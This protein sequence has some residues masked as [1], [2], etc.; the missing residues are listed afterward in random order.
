MEDV[1]RQFVESKLG[2]KNFQLKP[3]NIGL[4]GGLVFKAV[5]TEDNSV[6]FFVKMFKENTEILAKDVV[7]LDV[8]RQLPLRTSSSPHPMGVGKA[9][10]DGSSYGFFAQTV[11]KGVP[12]SSMMSDVGSKEEHSEERKAAMDKLEVAIR[13]VGR[14]LAELWSVRVDQAAK[15]GPKVQA[16]YLDEL[17]WTTHDIGEIAQ[18]IS[19]QDMAIL[20]ELDLEAVKKAAVLL[21]ERFSSRPELFGVAGYEHTDTN[22][23]NLFFD[24]NKDHLTLIDTEGVLKS[25]GKDGNPIGFPI[26][27]KIGFG[28]NSIPN[29]GFRNGLT[30]NEVRLLTAAFHQAYNDAISPFETR[31]GPLC[32]SDAVN[33]MML[34]KHSGAT[35]SIF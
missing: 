15:V 35:L 33:M 2:M 5:D 28:E 14:S 9:I 30:E 19:P 18:G 34:T 31:P 4:S 7:S 22:P 24:A 13:H 3:V 23:D 21:K 1:L 20:H 6:R 29:E 10:I 8:L 25:V 12:V 17:M 16:E 32:S 11:A 26:R 27:D